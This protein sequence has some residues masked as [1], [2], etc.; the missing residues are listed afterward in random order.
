VAQ[1]FLVA[2]RAGAHRASAAQIFLKSA[3]F[4]DDSFSS[5]SAIQ[6]LMLGNMRPT[7]CGPIA[8]V[9]DVEP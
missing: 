8:T 4:T 7:A 5:P 1:A 2:Y 6:P 3:F 9:L